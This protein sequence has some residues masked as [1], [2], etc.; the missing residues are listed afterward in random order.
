MALFFFEFCAESVEAVCAAESGGADRIELCSQLT[1]GGTTP[2]R[3]LM[4]ASVRAVS[5]P[6]YVLDSSPRRGFCFLLPGI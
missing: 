5:I 2:T 6:I 1:L 3:E 4:A